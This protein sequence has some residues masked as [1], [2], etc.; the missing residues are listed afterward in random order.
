MRKKDLWIVFGA[1]CAAVLLAVLQFRTG[2]VPTA[3]WGLSF[4]QGGQPPVG[5]ASMEV[6][7]SYNAR[8][9]GDTSQPVLY[10]TFD[11]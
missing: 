8:Y 9:L 11:A 5:P 1:V 10:L 3:S 4:R 7:R 6:L 2:A